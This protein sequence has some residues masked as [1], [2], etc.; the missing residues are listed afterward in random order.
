VRLVIAC[1]P[2]GGIGLDNNL[3]WDS[4]AGDLR[5]FKKLTQ[6]QVV[7]MGR[8]TWESLPT[9]PLPNRLNFV[10]TSKNLDLP[11]NAVAVKDLTPF[12][13]Y[14]TAWLIG[15]ASLVNSSWQYIDEVHLTRTHS[16]YDCDTFLDLVYLENNYTRVHIEHYADHDYEIWE[17]L[18]EAVPRPT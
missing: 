18:N 7:I 4:I 12:E 11:E 8:N 5:R 9:K 3:P 1:D 16:Q 10:V 15:G 13:H 2:T 6:D 14:P 17:R